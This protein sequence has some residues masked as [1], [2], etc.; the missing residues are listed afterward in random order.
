MNWPMIL[1]HGALGSWDEVI[2]LSIV[3]IFFIIMA[4]AWVRSRAMQGDDS[5]TPVDT[6]SEAAADDTD[7]FTLD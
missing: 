4:V 5:I 6:P 2:F 1:A 3:A 7:R